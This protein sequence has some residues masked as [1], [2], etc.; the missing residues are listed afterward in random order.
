M[1]VSGLWIGPVEKQFM[2]GMGRFEKF[3]EWA[4]PDQKNL[5]AG[6][7]ASKMI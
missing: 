4:G 2:T 1:L 5:R 7:A 3:K 6:R